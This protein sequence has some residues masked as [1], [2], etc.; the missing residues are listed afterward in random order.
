MASSNTSTEAGLGILSWTISPKI[1]N[2]AKSVKSFLVAAQID[3]QR[4]TT[5]GKGCKE[6]ISSNESE[7]GR[8]ENRRVEILIK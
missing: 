7:D 8:A 4:L 6:P 5:S 2:R 3:A 1:S